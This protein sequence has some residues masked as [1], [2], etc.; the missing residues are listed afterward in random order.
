MGFQIN[1]TLPSGIEVVNSYARI[2][3]MD[4][5][6]DQSVILDFSFWKDQ[7]AADNRIPTICN[8]VKITLTQE[9]IEG[10]EAF[11]S[12]YD[13]LIKQAYILSKETEEFA[14]ATDVL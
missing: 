2:E 3:K 6:K 11:K 12:A 13:E 5:S 4:G 9:Q 7:E 10:S 8:D 1:K 14:E